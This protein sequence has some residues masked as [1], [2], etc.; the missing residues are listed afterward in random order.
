MTSKIS[1]GDFHQAIKGFDIVLRKNDLK[2]LKWEAY[3]RFDQEDIDLLIKGDH[4][5]Y[6]LIDRPGWKNG[7][8]TDPMLKAEIANQEAEN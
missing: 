4:P 8:I 1:F 7:E 5:Y 6:H 3:N 2:I